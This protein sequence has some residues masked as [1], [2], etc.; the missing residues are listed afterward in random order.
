MSVEHLRTRT[1][2]GGQIQD[3]PKQI[4]SILAQLRALTSDTVT[5]PCADE[6]LHGE[7]MKTW[8]CDYH[9]MSRTSSHGTPELGSALSS[10]PCRSNPTSST[11]AMSLHASPRSRL[12]HRQVCQF[13]ALPQEKAIKQI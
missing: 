7:S 13:L 10:S 5:L 11:S 8:A 3:E 2:T 9:R 12:A 6:I 1:I 4:V